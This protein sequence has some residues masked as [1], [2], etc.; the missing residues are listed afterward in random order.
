MCAA[1]VSDEGE[2]LTGRH[3]IQ[4]VAERR[5]NYA[6]LVFKVNCVGIRV[7]RPPKQ[8]KLVQ[9]I[10]LSIENELQV[11]KRVIVG[12]VPSKIKVCGKI[13]ASEAR[14]I[15]ATPLI[16]AS[17]I[18][19]IAVERVRVTTATRVISQC[20]RVYQSNNQRKQHKK[21][22]LGHACYVK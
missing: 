18:V 12:I 22:N 3:I 15:I 7:E 11:H 17:A 4:F 1:N 8:Q 19:N 14:P 6:I 9:V 2:V 16:F 13:D 10:P 5:P 20:Y 21:G